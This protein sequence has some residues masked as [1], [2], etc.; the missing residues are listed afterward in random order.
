MGAAHP[1][2]QIQVSGQA[3]AVSQGQFAK[4]RDRA[5]SGQSVAVSAGTL[6]ASGSAADADWLA[7]ANASGVVFADRLNTSVLL[8]WRSTDGGLQS[9]IS[10]DG[11]T[12][13]SGSNASCKFDVLNIDGT[14]SGQL[15]IPFP[16]TFGPGD[17]IWFSVRVKAPPQQAYQ[18]WPSDGDGHKILILSRDNNGPAPV[19]SNQVN[20]VVVQM[21]HNENGFTA[22]WQDGVNTAISPDVA[23]SSAANST[24]FRAQSSIDR[25][26]NRLTGTNPDTGAAWSTWQQERARWGGTYGARSSPG[27]PEYRK[28]IGDPFSG[29]FRQYANEWI[30]VT[31]RLAIV[32]FGG[33]GNRL[34]MW[35]ARQGQG[36]QQLFDKQ[37]LTLGAGPVFNALNLM[38]YRS[39]GVA[40]GR[41]ISARTNNITGVT[42]H[43]CGLS[44]PIGVG[45]VSFNATTQRLTWAGAGEL[46]GSSRGFSASNGITLINVPSASATNSYLV[47]ELTGTLPSTNQTDTVTIA[48]GRND[49]FVHYADSIISTQSINA[50]GGYVPDMPAWVQSTPAT[51]AQIANTQM[52]SVDPNPPLNAG[53][54]A[55]GGLGNGIRMKVE[56]WTGFALDT[57]TSRLYSVASGGHNDYGG[58]EVNYLA[59]DTETPG[60]VEAKPPTPSAQI[61][62]CGSYYA[63]G[64]PTSRHQYYGAVFSEQADAI[65][66]MGGA[67][68][69]T[70]GG[71]H[72]ATDTYDI[73]SNT[74]ST[75]GQHPSLPPDFRGDVIGICADPSTGDVYTFA[76]NSIAKWDAV[77]NTFTVLNTNFVSNPKGQNGPTACDTSRNRIFLVGGQYSHRHL[78]SISGNSV[79]QPTLSGAAASAVQNCS[80]GSMM[81]YVPEM[82]AYLLCVGGGS[83]GVVY[84]INAS[85]FE[86]TSFASNASIPAV[87]NGNGV[88]GKFAYVPR[89]RG[90]V[91]VT[92]HAQNAWFLRAW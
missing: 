43:V 59:L 19:G 12:F 88:Y 21:A 52:S 79:T 15:S 66:L 73:S 60:W 42:F 67:Q 83:Q 20:E 80:G 54:G 37:N 4:T 34:T 18:P 71:F 56:A 23:F 35:A 78:Y 40:G 87:G 49:T 77:D 16:R 84:R 65:V 6:S 63:D 76:Q 85:T 44:T 27:A 32:A 57:R 45:T 70:S 51:W 33:A 28:G 5:M 72:N 30:T 25:G 90:C 31:A 48:D 22:Y 26:I 69:C 17:T 39:G 13:P 36:Y 1:T 89:L 7:R 29:Q 81:V 64:R 75:S 10:V 74:Y 11:T 62:N 2:P 82:D 14:S 58:N 68:W 24:D 47:A 55:G 92:Q 91:L 3:L 53:I 61:T 46:T 8:T 38:P 86:C 41:K 9:R 50:P